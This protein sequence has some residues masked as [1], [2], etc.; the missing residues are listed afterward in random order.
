MR[1]KSLIIALL[2]AGMTLATGGEAFAG[3]DGFG[4]FPY[5][6]QNVSGAYQSE[7]QDSVGR[8]RHSLGLNVRSGYIL[9]TNDFFRGLNWD[10]K[11]LRLTSSAHLQY[12][13]AFPENSTLGSLY[14][15]AYQGIG[16]AVNTFYDHEE[17]GEPIALYL[18]QGATLA[19]LTERLTLDGEWNFGL[20]FGWHPFDG[21]LL[22]QAREGENPFNVVVGSRMNAYINGSLLLNWKISP[23]WKAVAGIEINHFSNGNTTIPN[24]GVNTVGARLG[25]AGTIN[26]A[27]ARQR[28]RPAAERNDDAL[29][30]A[31][32]HYIIYDFVAFGAWRSKA[33]L[34]NEE[35]YIALGSF[36]VAGFNFSPLYNVNKHFRTGLSLDAQYDASANIGDHVAGLD[37]NGEIQFYRPDFMD[38]F[39]MG[40]SARAELVM[41][42]FSVNV[43]I[44]HN[45]LYRGKDTKGLYQIFALKTAVSRHVY[46]HIGYKLLKFRHPNNLMLGIGMRLGGNR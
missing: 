24:A 15:T 1:R 11:P 28:R 6:E 13:I 30:L 21:D 34:W 23:S 29:E 19:R 5:E 38:Q 2:A 25:F 37:E 16:L 18:F 10:A 7:H 14:P 27:G 26:P 32:R 44:G 8:F 4:G 46:I 35:P 12:S 40:L 41:P 17:I 43:G 39:S 9:P 31:D 33:V 45:F 20:S 3:Q 22:S 36:G 42:I